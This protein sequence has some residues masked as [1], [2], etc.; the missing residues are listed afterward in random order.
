[1]EEQ[2]KQ[3]KKIISWSGLGCRI[4]SVVGIVTTLIYLINI[5][6]GNFKKNY[7][8]LKNTVIILGTSLTVGA[9]GSIA[10]SSKKNKALTE[11]LVESTNSASQIPIT[12]YSDLNEDN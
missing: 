9:I 8:F 5:S 2:I 12:E 3:A 7:N 11:L 1:M 10:D 4:F 6:S